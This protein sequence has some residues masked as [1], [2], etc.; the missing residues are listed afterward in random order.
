MTT[1]LIVPAPSEAIALQVI[2]NVSEWD[3]QHFVEYLTTAAFVLAWPTSGVPKRIN[4]AFGINPAAYAAFNLPGHDGLDLYAPAGTPIVA[5]FEG[6][7]FRTPAQ[8]ALGV[9]HAYGNHVRLRHQAGG[10][11]YHTVYAHLS[12]IDPAV[13]EGAVLATGALLGLAGSTGN[14]TGPHLHLTLKRVGHYDPAQPAS[15]TNFP[16][17]I[18]DPTPFFKDLPADTL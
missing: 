16:H 8:I 5:A 17:D 12:V 6:T 10:F 7:V 1:I 13:S 11:E 14:S 2:R 3:A 9:Q 15:L 4:Q 18:I